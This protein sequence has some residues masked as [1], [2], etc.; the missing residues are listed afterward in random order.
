MHPARTPRAPSCAPQLARGHVQA[1]KFKRTEPEQPEAGLLMRAL[2][3]FNLPKIVA[4][5]LGVFM[6]LLQDLFPAVCDSMPR[7]RDQPF[8]QLV[9][10]VAREGQ[11]Q[12]SEYFV[13]NVVDLQELLDIR[14][15]VFVMG[16]SGAGKSAAW[17]QLAR[18]W[19]KGG[20][21]GKTTYRDINPKS[22]TSNELYGF[23]N[24]NTR[25]WKDG[26]LSYAV[27]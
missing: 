27:S 15:C 17:Q 26:M 6:G 19:T 22:L 4:D 11:L 13:Q 18:A 25:E 2:R 16:S 7:A 12:P 20:V 21:R 10:A 5:D 8:E 1:G 24:M 14:H 3:D 9:A 23:V